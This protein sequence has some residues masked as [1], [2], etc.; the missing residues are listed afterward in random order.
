LKHV[1]GPLALLA[2]LVM[3]AAPHSTA[4]EPATLKLSTLAPRGSVYHRVLQDVGEAFKAARGG[5]AKAVVYPDGGQGGESDVVRRLRVGQLDGALLTVM[6]LKEIDAS[7][8]ALQFMPMMFRSWDEVDHVRD[9]MREMFETRLAQKGFVVLFWGDAGWVRFFSKDAMAYPEDFKRARIFVWEGDAPQMSLMKSLGY[10]PVGLPV[11]DMLPSLETGMIDV[12]PM[13]PI[14]ALAGQFDRVTPHML[15]VKWVPIVGA[16]VMRKSTYDALSP[17]V[18][19]AI[20]RAAQG[21]SAQLRSHRVNQDEVSIRAMQDRGL[22]VTV[23]TPEM[24]R[25][26]QALG[27]TVWPQV[28]GAM[29]PAETFDQVQALVTEFRARKRP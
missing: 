27:A 22:R 28:R 24:T 19:E 7:V 9:Q 12:V 29:V 23:P 2:C 20:L 15:D 1:H 8:A 6:G 17:A 10:R 4:A 14:W 21:A 26:W 16:A 25:A 13:V 3:A 18:Q 5:S 11:A